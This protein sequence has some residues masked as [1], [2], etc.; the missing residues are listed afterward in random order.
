MGMDIRI[1]L[2][3]YVKIT[4]KKTVDVPKVRRICS[5]L[6]LGADHPR[7]SQNDNRNNKFCSHCGK[8]IVDQNYV[9]VEELS[10]F[11]VISNAN[12][13]FEDDLTSVEYLENVLIP[14]NYP[15]DRF[16]I[17]EES[18]GEINLIEK[19]KVIANQIIWFKEKYAQHLMALK[20]AYGIENV[21]VCWGLVHYWS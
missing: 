14:N 18:S 16:D 19:E 5:A 7:N 15:P 8:E 12:S 3:P 21:K 13:E 4:G 10:P 1:T 11:R 6:M 9:E 2:T 20:T 17:E